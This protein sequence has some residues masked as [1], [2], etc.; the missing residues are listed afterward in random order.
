MR[1]C[2]VLVYFFTVKNKFELNLHVCVKDGIQQCSLGFSLDPQQQREGKL[3]KVVQKITLNFLDGIKAFTE[4]IKEIFRLVFYFF[5]F[6]FS[7]KFVY[8]SVYANKST[9]FPALTGLLL[10]F[11]KQ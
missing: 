1:A 2:I 11:E 9:L 4:R 10:S 7:Y 5:N 3:T 8:I 6:F